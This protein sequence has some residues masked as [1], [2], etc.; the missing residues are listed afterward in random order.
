VV[1]GAAGAPGLKRPCPGVEAAR[2]GLPTAPAL[3]RIW[4]SA[5]E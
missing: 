2:H 4:C 1:P 5:H 3:P